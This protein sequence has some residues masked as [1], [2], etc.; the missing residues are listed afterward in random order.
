VRL[1]QEIVAERFVPT[2]RSMLVSK[3]ARLG[4]TQD[5]IGKSLGISQAAV[6][7]H[8]AGRQR[9][10][11]VLA[12]DPRVAA[13][14][15]RIAEGFHEE[16]L[17]ST[18]A[19][20]QLMTL[21]RELSNRGPVCELH[22]RDM[23]GLRGIGCDLC[24]VEGG[25]TVMQEQRVLSSLKS[26]IRIL[27]DTPAFGHLIPSVGANVCMALARATDLPDVAGVPG[28]IDSQK[29]AVTIHGAPE[30]GASHH[31]AEVL[32]GVHAFDA[33]K[34]AAINM[35]TEERLLAAL[36]KRRLSCV[37]VEA[38]HESDRKSLLAQLKRV[39]KTPDVVYHR[40][41][42]AV[43]P[44]TYVFGKDAETVAKLVR[45]VAIDLE[46]SRGL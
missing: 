16:R 43:E 35:R 6:S 10:E 36:K 14:V 26:A 29:G 25:G 39:G 30:F 46:A 13:T 23:P 7:K 21:V 8:R 22:E 38:S 37:E 34:A 2:V 42:F 9:L 3:M 17:S 40:G 12:K 27:E 1:P 15:E 19:M 24:V 28:R 32:L 41:A 33:E 31:V 45:S 44:I 11:P 20:A 5:Q 4:M 18:E